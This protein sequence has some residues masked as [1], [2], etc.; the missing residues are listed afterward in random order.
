MRR[1]EQGERSC[2]EVGR[3]LIGL[4]VGGGIMGS[5][6]GGEGVGQRAQLVGR[7]GRSR[8]LGARIVGMA[9][10]WSDGASAASRQ[11]RL[12]LPKQRQSNTRW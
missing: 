3:E 5:E 1:I 6:L 12:K 4:S 7:F 9:G 8:L 2:T 10:G 11:R